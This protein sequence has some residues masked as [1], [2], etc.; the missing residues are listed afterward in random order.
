MK[1][2]KIIFFFPIFNRGGLEE[3]AKSLIK[4]FLKKNFKIE[5]ITYSKRNINISHKNLKIFN[6]ISNEVDSSNFFKTLNCG[7]ILNDRLKKNDPKSSIVLSLQNSVISI[8][9]AKLNSY[10]IIIK[11]ANPIKALF[12]SG[13]KFKNF[14][15]FIFKIFFYNFADKVIV[16]S[17]YNRNTLSRYILNKKKIIRIYNPIKMDKYKF[18][19]NKKNIILYVGR[20]V[21]EKGLITLIKAFKII[22]SKKFKLIIVGDGNYAKYLKLL[23]KSEGL[24]NKVHM[25]GWISSPKKYYLKSK[26][27]VLPTLFEAF[28]NV[29][30]EAMHYNLACIASKNSGGPDEILANGKYG[31]QFKKNDIY[32]LKNKIDY[33]INNKTITKNKIA[34]AK[35]SLNKYSKFKNLNKYYEL[36]YNKDLR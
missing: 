21:K 15:A 25:T 20:I 36:I 2:G 22:S 12:L 17:E 27:L 8:L 35:K 19:K 7:L 4:F 30:V 5:L 11:N 28:G 26:I 23:I 18:I 13:N 34:L 24:K 29:L 14:F 1:Y 16:N 31:F 6:K 33:C 3:V 9:F 10:K 32:D